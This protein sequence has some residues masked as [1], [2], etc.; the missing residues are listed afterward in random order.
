MG[1]IAVTAHVLRP[2]W[3]DA[4]DRRF[5]RERY[6]ARRI[7]ARLVTDIR[8]VG[9][10]ERVAPRAVDQISDALHPS[11]TAL[12]SRARGDAQFTMAAATPDP[13]RQPPFAPD[14]TLARLARV[15]NKPIDITLSEDDWLPSQ[16]PD[17]EVEALRAARIGLVVPMATGPAGTE[18]LLVLGVKR[19]EEPYDDDD[20]ELLA[21]I[22]DSLALL[23][24][25]GAVTPVASELVAEC[26]SCG[27]CYGSGVHVCEKEGASLTATRLPRVLAAR[28]RI[29]RRLGHGGM[30][31]VYEARDL[32]LDRLVA[33]KVMREALTGSKDAADRFQQEARAAARFSHP[34][35]VTVH[36]YGVTQ[37]QI[38]FLIMEL[39]DG[40]TLRA[41]LQRGGALN[42]TR[43]LSLVREIASAVDAAH[44]Q[45][46]LH[47][48]LKPENIFLISAGSSS[49]ESA[50]VVDFG[51]AKSMALDRGGDGAHLSTNPALLLGTPRYMAPEQ[52]RGEEPRPSWD[53]W[54]LAILAYEMLAGAHPF[55]G[56]GIAAL[57]GNPAA[58][59]AH[60]SSRLPRGAA[61]SA[62]LFAR[63]LSSDPALRPPTALAFLAEFERVV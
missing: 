33:A 1:A 17:A 10:F 16:L 28:Y 40:A 53:L 29:E 4:L 60:L 57:P 5:F 15:L 25:R 2:R 8:E 52:L 27:T 3:L 32:A 36:D 23:I 14:S 38:A 34:N 18:A 42:E 20:H 37:E 30:G 61:A 62:A 56:L 19:S 26:P 35:V 45:R 6:D 21:A 47:R 49:R 11:S 50:K 51:I 59:E 9:S 12:L 58:F 39:L 48:D 63:A 44:Q 7:L 13:S 54:A 41:E 31:T 43:T 55:D 22:G 46:I 24:D